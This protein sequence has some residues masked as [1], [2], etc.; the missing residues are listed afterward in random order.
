ME[1]YGQIEKIIN[2]TVRQAIETKQ[3]NFGALIQSMETEF[4]RRGFRNHPARGGG[5]RKF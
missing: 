1:D 3:F 5:D 2:D 4:T